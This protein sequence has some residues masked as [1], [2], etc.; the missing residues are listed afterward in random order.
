[1]SASKVRT[2][3]N[4]KEKP[5]EK[6]RN[7]AP[8]LTYYPKQIEKQALFLEQLGPTFND[9]WRHR[10]PEVRGNKK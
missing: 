5:Y 2:K 7:S 3:L 8:V 10:R 9:E 4:F 1:M 6:I